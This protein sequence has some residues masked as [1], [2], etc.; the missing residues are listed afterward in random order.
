MQGE[1]ASADVETARSYPEGL[2]RIMNEGGCTTQIFNVNET[3]LCWKKM[4]SRTFIAK[5]K[6][7]LP[8]FRASEDRL[9][10][11]RG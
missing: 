4:T 8:G 9:T 1:A 2:V 6:K 3:A 7:S 10:L 5:E 11:V